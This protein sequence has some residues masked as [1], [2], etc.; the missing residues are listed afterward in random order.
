MDRKKIVL[1]LRKIMSLAEECLS[2]LEDSATPPRSVGRRA[3][4]SKE[5]RLPNLD[6]DIPLR[7][8][9]KQYAK[10]MSGPKKFVLLLSR[11][12]KGDLKMEVTLKEIE[13]N[14][15]KMK[16]PSLLAIDFSR[17]YPGRA[18]EYDW[19]ESKKTGVFN[20]RPGWM[21]IVKSSNGK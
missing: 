11:L 16:S 20:L 4:P 18:R 14:W 3:V 17:S 19:V 12:V 15:N 6:F 21:K 5:P 8:F 9:I 13:K 2:S 1:S 7:P 10:G